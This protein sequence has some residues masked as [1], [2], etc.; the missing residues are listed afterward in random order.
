MILI[1]LS[2]QV[3]MPLLLLVGV[4]AAA[5]QAC[6]AVANAD[7]VNDDVLSLGLT[8]LSAPPC[9][10][11][12]TLSSAVPLYAP[13]LVLLLYTSG[14]VTATSDV[15]VTAAAA[16]AGTVSTVEL[17]VTAAL[18]TSLYSVSAPLLYLISPLLTPSG[19]AA[20]HCIS[21]T[22]ANEF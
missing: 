9:T 7:D 12:G 1:V 10:I 2:T 8:S 3:P 15:D 22:L 6:A 19:M 20:C 16:G 5:I 21:R 14:A 11:G 4:A 18:V 17:C 13:L